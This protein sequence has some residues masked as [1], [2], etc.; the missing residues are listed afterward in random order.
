MLKTD[1][2]QEKH[3]IDFSVDYCYTTFTQA[4]CLPVL[5]GQHKNKF[6]LWFFF[7]KTRPPTQ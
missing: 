3:S 2:F 7:L 6:C 4:F 1:I 5:K